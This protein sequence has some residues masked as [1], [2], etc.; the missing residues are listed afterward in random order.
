MYHHHANPGRPGD[1]GPFRG[2]GLVDG[3]LRLSSAE[4]IRAFHAQATVAADE[5]KATYKDESGKEPRSEFLVSPDQ[6]KRINAW[7]GSVEGREKI[8]A[9]S[10]RVISFVT[11]TVGR[12]HPGHDM[13]HV[14]YKDPLSALRIAL[15]EDLSPARQLFVIPS[16]LHDAG[17]LFEPELFDTPQSG[18]LGVDHT[19]LGFAITDQLLGDALASETHDPELAVALKNLRSEILNAVLD[20]Q[21]GNS[22]T[23]L[24]AQYVQRADREQLVG[25]EALHRFI[26]FDVGFYGL[27]IREQV[28]QTASQKL[29]LPG[30]ADD[31][32]LFLHAEFYARNLFPN[33]GS[34]ANTHTDI[35]K[36]E[37]GRFLWLAATPAMREQI[38]SPELQRDLGKPAEPHWSKKPF[39]PELWEQIRNF[40]TAQLIEKLDA[41]R[42]GRALEEL[43]D[44][45]IHPRF[46]TRTDIAPYNNW[47]TIR[48]KLAALNGDE[49]QRFGRAISYGL[50]LADDVDVQDRKIVRD[51]LARFMDEPRG[52]LYK[53][54]RL[55]GTLQDFSHD[56]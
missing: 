20:H 39:S 2:P 53:V 7:L 30:A 54:A 14:L 47:E 31:R 51:S 17:R 11:E 52:P 25:Y 10:D 5:F 45:F 36:I 41:F 46:A 1:A 23:S 15:E 18:T 42:A 43:T 28:E 33:E 21:S 16:L 50:M 4:R 13:R 9:L 55:I 32:H 3:N 37:T 22:R 40:D 44:L 24:I 8:A 6:E 19:I 26:S 34:H 35:G 27:E 49:A 29:P 12:G 38:F 48:E 56:A